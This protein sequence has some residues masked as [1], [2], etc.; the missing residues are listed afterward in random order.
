MVTEPADRNGLSGTFRHLLL[1]GSSGINKFT[2]GI[3]NKCLSEDCLLF[4][5]KKDS[6]TLLIQIIYYIGGLLSLSSMSFPHILFFL[7]FILSPLCLFSLTFYLSIFSPL[8]FLPS[9]LTV[10]SFIEQ[11]VSRTSATRELECHFN[12]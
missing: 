3:Y 8:I 7:S 11:L 4:L 12:S 6:V 10:K 1:S 2:L 9:F 5:L